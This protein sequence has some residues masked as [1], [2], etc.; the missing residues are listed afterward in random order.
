MAENLEQIKKE[1]Q[2]QGNITNTDNIDPSTIFSWFTNSWLK[3][4]VDEIIESQK[5]DIFY[6][7]QIITSIFKMVFWVLILIFIALYTYVFVQ[8]KPELSNSVLD[9]FCYLLIWDIKNTNPTCSSITT[10]NNEYIKKIDSIKNEQYNSIISVVENYYKI[11]N[12]SKSKEVMFLKEKTDSKLPVLQ[13]ISDFEELKNQFEPFLRNKIR[14]Y[15]IDIKDDYTFKAKCDAYSYY[16]DKEI[17]WFDWTDNEY[18]EWKSISY[19][20][21]FLN[22]IEKQ[23]TNFTHINRQ[24]VFTSDSIIWEEQLYTSKTSFYLELKYNSNNLSL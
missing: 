24:K 5:K 16:Y 20:N 19:A 4:E 2:K 15:D 13:I 7:L 3:Q 17:R 22:F 14:C 6:Y 12:F 9:P 21:S 8:E 18:I 10:L 11:E 23:S 1:E